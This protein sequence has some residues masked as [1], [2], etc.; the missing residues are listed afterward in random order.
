MLG[1]LEQE[2]YLFALFVFILRHLLQASTGD[3]TSNLS[4]DLM[5]LFLCFLKVGFK[6]DVNISV[7][8]FS[9]KQSLISNFLMRGV[10]MGCL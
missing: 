2:V 5:W 7:K 8:N 9:I 6:S 10:I 4:S 1:E 3:R